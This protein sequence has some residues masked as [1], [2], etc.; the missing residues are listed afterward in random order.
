MEQD[1]KKEKYEL[2]FWTKDENDALVKKVLA[3]HRAE[4]VKER[5]VQKMRLAFPIRKENYAFLGTVIF[6]ADV[7]AAKDIS[8]DLN[9]ETGVLRYFL[10]KA[11][12]PSTDNRT[13][14]PEAPRE[15]RPFFRLRSEAKTD[16]VLTN[17]ALEKKIEE[18]LN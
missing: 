17:E 16:Q 6:S 4:I 5:P 3:K 15:R 1:V 11:K 9:L 18:I 8:A 2:A 7:S 12:K 10:R 13:E 14:N